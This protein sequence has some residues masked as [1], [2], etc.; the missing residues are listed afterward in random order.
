MKYKYNVLIIVLLLVHS[1]FAQEKDDACNYLDSVK[2]ELKKTWPDNKTV[3]LV[4]HGHSVPSGYFKTPKVHTLESYPYKTLKEVKQIYTHAVVNSIT[5][6]I[7]GEH[8]EQGEKRFKED[9]LVHRPDVLFIDYALNDRNIGLER[10]KIAWEKM[11][12]QAKE[13][14]T[15]VIL[16]TPTPDLNEDIKSI[17]TKLYKHTQ[18][19]REL[20]QKH[21]VGLVD[22]YG[23]FREL[24]NTKNLKDYMAQGNHINEKG[25]E[26]VAK[27]IRDFFIEDFQSK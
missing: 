19:I 12:V 9:V 4:F 3:N 15:K 8:S 13:Y 10:A 25:H 20:G 27:A 11:I 7:G 14:G 2:S 21:E 26:I 22:S 24:A 5:T 18:Q 1:A 17:D 6:S 23:L 16:M